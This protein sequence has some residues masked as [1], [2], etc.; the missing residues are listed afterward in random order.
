MFRARAMCRWCDRRHPSHWLT[1]V[2]KSFFEHTWH[3]WCPSTSMAAS[4]MYSIEFNVS[5]WRRHRDN[6]LANIVRLLFQGQMCSGTLLGFGSLFHCPTGCNFI[7]QCVSRCSI[8]VRCDASV[9]VVFFIVWP[10][11][12]LLYN[13]SAMS[14]SSSSGA[15]AAPKAKGKAKGRNPASYTHLTLPTNRE[16]YIAGFCV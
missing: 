9:Q 12:I 11:H 15:S 1:R 13:C 14:T 5:E 6:V 8:Y 10:E 3:R 7:V 4:V 16:V 2:S